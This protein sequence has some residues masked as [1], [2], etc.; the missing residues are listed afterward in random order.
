MKAYT[1]SI[2][3]S[4]L[5]TLLSIAMMFFIYYIQEQM[6]RESWFYSPTMISMILV[7]WL[8]ASLAINQWMITYKIKN[9]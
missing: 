4:I 2:I 1:K 9:A 8:F 6:D 5:W 3:M 7:D